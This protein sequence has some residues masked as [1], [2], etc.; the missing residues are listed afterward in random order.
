M[1]AVRWPLEFSAWSASSFSAYGVELQRGF[2]ARS[3]RYRSHPR[4]RLLA[5]AAAPQ[6]LY[7]T[8]SQ[9]ACNRP[10]PTGLPSA[11]PTFELVRSSTRHHC[12]HAGITCAPDGCPYVSTWPGPTILTWP[13]VFHV[14]PGSHRGVSRETGQPSSREDKKRIMSSMSAARRPSATM[15]MARRLHAAGTPAINT[16]SWCSVPAECCPDLS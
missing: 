1:S 16:Q 11:E 8:S 2:T 13:T 6:E 15:G 3:R 9:W 7:R 12:H 4:P 5:S 10:L 14:K